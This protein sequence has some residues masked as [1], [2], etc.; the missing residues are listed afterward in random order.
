MRRSEIAGWDV[1]YLDDAATRWRAA[2]DESDRLFSQYRQTV[3]MPTGPARGAMRHMTTSAPTL[4]SYRLRVR[5]SGQ[6]PRLLRTA[7][8][9]NAMPCRRP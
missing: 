7:P 3:A 2:A 8:P 5:F 4:V 9:I 6:L 1:S